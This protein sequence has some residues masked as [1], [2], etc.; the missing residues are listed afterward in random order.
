MTPDLNIGDKV[1][2][3]RLCVIGEITHISGR[4][5]KWPYLV[6]IPGHGERSYSADELEQLPSGTVLTLPPYGTPLP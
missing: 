1:R 4:L 5:K 3:K 6:K 2:V